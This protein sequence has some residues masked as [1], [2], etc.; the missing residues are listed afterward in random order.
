MMS[1]TFNLVTTKC[2]HFHSWYFPFKH[3][4]MLFLSLVYIFQPIKIA[5]LNFCRYLKTSFVIDLL[6]CMPWDVIYQVIL[7]LLIYAIICISPTIFSSND[8]HC[9]G[10][11]CNGKNLCVFIYISSRFRSIPVPAFACL[12]NWDFPA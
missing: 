11:I 3:N 5:N 10:N 6:G 4:I 12:K 9:F 8:Q 2:K 7:F 1:Y